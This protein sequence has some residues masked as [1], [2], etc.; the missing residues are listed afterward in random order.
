LRIPSFYN[1][2]NIIQHKN[3]IAKRKEMLS[4]S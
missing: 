3:D 2:F 1:N 4:F